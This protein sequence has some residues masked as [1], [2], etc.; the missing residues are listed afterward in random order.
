MADLA[1]GGFELCGGVGFE[2]EKELVFPGAAVNGTAFDF[3]EVDAV[4]G[5]GLERG[6]QGA[7]T[8]G[9]AHGDGHFVGVR[10]RRLRFA[11]GS[12]K[13]KAGE[14][15]CI[16]LEIGGE[17]YAGVVFGGAA[18][19]D[20]GGRFVTASEDFADAAGGVFGGD[21]FD[22]GMGEEEAFAL[23][24]GHGMRSDGANVVE[25]SAWASDEVMFD[26]EDGF[27]GDGEGA[28]EEEIVDTNYRAGE[29][30]FDR[31]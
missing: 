13:K 24:E 3:L 31:G 20:G 12:Q 21:A 26:G 5:E 4:F 28:F 16:V 19:G 6:E 7:G 11:R 27:G 22:V 18:A 29:G 8:V 15:F 25:R 2:V 23:R 9:E 30:V 1:Q 14:I 17:D 10:Q